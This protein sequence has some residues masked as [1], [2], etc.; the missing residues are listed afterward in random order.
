MTLASPPGKSLAVPTDPIWRLS[1]AQYHGMVAS[2]IL[3]EDD[4]VELLEGW[5][6]TKMPKNPLHTLATK[7]TSSQ[8]AAVLPMGWFVNVQE[9]VTTADSEPEPVVVIVRG[10]RR[11]YRERHPSPADVVLVVEVSDTTL[12]RDQTLKLR[13]YAKARI[14]VYWIVNLPDQQ[15]EVYSDPIGAAY[16]SQ[17]VYRAG[18]T[19][20]VL[21]D[22]K[23]AA[24]ISVDAFWS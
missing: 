13:I 24:R 18:E 4:P 1:V 17:T 20:P 7:L 16:T 2:G 8:L 12:A 11:D 23:E 14:P 6:V 22:G 10:Q 19:V 9:P 15:L 5:L 21:L 3:T